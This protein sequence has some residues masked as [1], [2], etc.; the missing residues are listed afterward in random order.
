MTE[1][2]KQVLTQVDP[3][4]TSQ[5]LHVGPDFGRIKTPSRMWIAG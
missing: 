4:A 1:A 3:T 5:I 2:K